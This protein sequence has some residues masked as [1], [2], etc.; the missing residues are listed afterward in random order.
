MI[1][2]CSSYIK[3]LKA[4]QIVFHSLMHIYMWKYKIRTDRTNIKSI[5][6][7]SGVGMVDNENFFCFLAMEI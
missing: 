5:I 7:K 4:L 3:V 6:M 2:Y 1:E